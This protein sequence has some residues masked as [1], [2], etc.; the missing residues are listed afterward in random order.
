MLLFRRFL[1]N[2]RTIG[3][4]APSS[5]TL[6]REMVAHLPERQ[7]SRVVE[8]GPGTG[9]FTGAIFDRIGPSGSVL[10]VDIEPDFVQ[11]LRERF[12]WIETVC[13]SAEQLETLVNDRGLAPLDHIVSGLPFASLPVETTGRVL[14]G[15]E[16]TLRRGGTFTAFQYVHA[17]VFSAAIQFR[18]DMTRRMGAAPRTRLVFRNFPPAVVM[19]WHRK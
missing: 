15:I 3:A 13:A 17:Y 10:A 19:T 8:L 1:R 14:N 7:Q 6:A 9:A 12:P 11:Q 18:Q 4:I 16:R 5:R 2:P